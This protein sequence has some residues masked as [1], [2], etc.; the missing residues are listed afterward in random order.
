M[1]N[2]EFELLKILLENKNI[3]MTRDTLLDRV[4]G[5]EYAGETN[6]IDVYIRYLRSKID[7]R[8]GMKMIQTVRGVGYVIREDKQG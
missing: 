7:E 4:C 5:Y 8:F 2:R 3:V 6:V 1:T